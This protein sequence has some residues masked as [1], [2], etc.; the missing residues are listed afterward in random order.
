MGVRDFEFDDT[1]EREQRR[2]QLRQS[3]REIR[4]DVSKSDNAYKSRGRDKYKK[5]I[6]N[7]RYDKYDMY[8]DDTKGNFTF[9]VLVVMLAF[10]FLTIVSDS[11]NSKVVSAKQELLSN[12]AFM[13]VT[14]HTKDMLSKN[15]LSAKAMEL[16]ASAKDKLL[17]DDTTETS[18]I[19]SQATTSDSVS[20]STTNTTTDNDETDDTDKEEND[21]TTDTDLFINTNSDDL[22]YA[23][24]SGLFD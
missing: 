24:E 4:G 7:A 5:N 20:V 21:L 16:M 8:E 10:V 3:V 2:K 23:V 6:K 22:N 14:S 11:N 19:E 18:D 15:D 12:E 9:K 17:K 1:I 13:Y